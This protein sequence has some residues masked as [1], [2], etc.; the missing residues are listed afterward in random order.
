MPDQFDPEGA[1]DIAPRGRK[2]PRL[3]EK[4]MRQKQDGLN[5]DNETD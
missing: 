4:V 2:C 3:I 5:D 1:G